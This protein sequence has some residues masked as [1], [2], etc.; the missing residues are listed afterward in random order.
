MNF[1]HSLILTICYDDSTVEQ[2]FVVMKGGVDM[3][4]VTYEFEK[5]NDEVVRARVCDFGGHKRADIRVFFQGKDGD[6]HP[7]KKGISISTELV[8]DLKLAIT[9]LEEAVN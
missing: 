9:K 4:K 6:W 2:V 8:G 7:T 3:E 1:F 5:G